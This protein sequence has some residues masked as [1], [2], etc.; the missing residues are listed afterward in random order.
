MKHLL[1]V[2]VILVGACGEDTRPVNIPVV[3]PGDYEAECQRLCTIPAGDDQCKPKHA[4]FCLASCRARTNGL[5]AACAECMLTGGAVIHGYLNSFDDPACAT[6]GPT[7]ISSCEVCDDGGAAPATPAL[8]SLCTLECAFYM[9]DPTPLACSDEGSA[10]CLADCAAVITARGRVCAQC[11]AD[12]TGT[13]RI[14]INDDCDCEPQFMDE[15]NFGCDDF[16][17]D[18]LP[19]T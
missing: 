12:Q 7:G 14:C 1:L 10:Q 15:P 9:Q 17:D 3:A 19:P 16:C 8:A 13:V 18:Q 2:L 5:P 11:L 6:G 4:E